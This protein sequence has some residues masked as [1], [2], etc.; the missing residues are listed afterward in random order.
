V[1]TD[2]RDR[3]IVEHL[4]LVGFLVSKVIAS[5]THLSRDDLAQAGAVALVKAVDAYDAERGV[6]FGAY[7][8][9]RILGGIRDE[10]RA[11]DW[12][13]RSTRQT[14]KETVAVQEQLTAALGRRPSTGELASALGVDR[15][16]ASEYEG[17]ASR[18]VGPYDEAFVGDE[19]SEV[20]LPEAELVVRERIEFAHAAVAA[21][22]ERLRY[23][24][25]EIYFHDRAVTE[26][27]EELGV[28]H[29]AVS[30]Q[31]SEGLRLLRLG[32]AGYLADETELPLQVPAP[33]TSRAKKYLDDLGGAFGGRRSTT[34]A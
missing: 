31:R 27:A 28:T 29:S 9:E 33:S 6:P 8:R 4:P 5:A 23:V 21:L 2:E 12:A 24:I 20:M 19:A 32:A 26:L 10:M 14:I 7:A 15:A 1:K 13:K 30:Q 25:E 11:T 17:L 16:T 22:P 3:M 18:R 34:L